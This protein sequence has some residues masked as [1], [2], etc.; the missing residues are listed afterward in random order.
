MMTFGQ[1]GQLSLQ[2]QM[3][4]VQGVNSGSKPDD[5]I[6]LPDNDLPFS[7]S[8]IPDTPTM[9]IC[10]ETFLNLK[11]YTVRQ[12][13]YHMYVRCLKNY[14]LPFFGDM[15]L[16]KINGKVV[17]KFVNAM[18]CQGM[19][20]KTIKY[21]VARLKSILLCAEADGIIT[22]P[23]IR[24]DYPKQL[25]MERPILSNEDFDRLNNHLLQENNFIS[26]ALLI[27]MHTG[28]RIGEACA[29]R[30]NDIDFKTSSIYIRQSVKRYYVPD[31]KR[32]VCELGEPKTLKSK[33]R[34][35]ISQWLADVLKQC[36]GKGF[37]CT[38]A[39]K[40]CNPETLRNALN[41]RL[42]ILGIPHVRFHD[43]R[44]GFATRAINGA[45]VDPKTVAEILGHER[46]DI[47]LDIYTSCTA[48]MQLEAMEQIQNLKQKE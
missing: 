24:P 11:K 27:V 29:L 36:Q 33:R 32:T 37:I 10:T 15:P 7:V 6:E 26:T 23:V 18:L 4:Y 46:C 38:G 12:S 47:T 19:N 45:G 22:M 34:I 2:M 42:K 20:S 25:K 17:Q 31:E 21:C 3:L 30:W 1:L 48:K 16:N 28:I 43:L 35:Y 8:E 39:E 13:T 5:L 44:H 9:K 41:K 14:I 40:F